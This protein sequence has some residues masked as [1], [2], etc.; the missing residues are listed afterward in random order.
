MKLLP[1][2][3]TCLPAAQ[4]DVIKRFEDVRDEAIVFISRAT[5]KR[6]NALAL[7]KSSDQ[8]LIESWLKQHSIIAEG[9]AY[10]ALYLS[11]VMAKQD[12]FNNDDILKK[13]KGLRR[14]VALF[15][16]FVENTS[17]N[18]KTL[19]ISD[20]NDHWRDSVSARDEAQNIITHLDDLFLTS[21]AKYVCKQRS[22]TDTCFSTMCGESTPA[23]VFLDVKSSA[24][25]DRIARVVDADTFE[26]NMRAIAMSTHNVDVISKRID[27]YIEDHD[28]LVLKVTTDTGCVSA[29]KFA[30]ATKDFVARAKLILCAASCWELMMDDIPS[31]KER[32]AEA[33]TQKQ[34]MNSNVDSV[35]APFPARILLMLDLWAETGDVKHAIEEVTKQGRSA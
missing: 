32:Q 26:E 5:T 1:I 17:G 2:V 31:L 25:K 11:L 34:D 33:N 14:S 21:W 29:Q 18:L 13:V 20:S 3:M 35:R 19:G 8:A 10:V 6:N 23:A 7:G 30:S 28:T 12:P 16:T 4:E 24:C 27:E 9:C 22:D 15:T